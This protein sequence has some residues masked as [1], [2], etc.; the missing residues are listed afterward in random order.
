MT[1]TTISFSIL[2]P[3]AAATVFA[4]ATSAQAQTLSGQQFIDTHSGKC[5][6][7][8]GESE[9]T[10]CFKA[11]GTTSY[12]DKS[13]G[14]DTGTWTVKGNEMCVTWSQEGVEDCGCQSQSKMGPCRGVK[15]GHFG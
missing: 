4:F 3:L 11:N 12:N 13:Y 8:W 15:M 6:S 14:K 9:G 7:Y 10:Q 2:A 5:I 1:P